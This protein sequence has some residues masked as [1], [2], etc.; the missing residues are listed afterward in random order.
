[1]KVDAYVNFNLKLD[2]IYQVVKSLVNPINNST[3]K[4]ADEMLQFN[5]KWNQKMNEYNNG[6]FKL[7]IK[8]GA[9]LPNKKYQ[10]YLEPKYV[11]AY[12]V[13]ELQYL[14]NEK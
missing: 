2:M 5:L 3:S 6:N 10:A 11:K 7:E 8:P 13:S 9:F 12:L 14:L 4:M 1:V